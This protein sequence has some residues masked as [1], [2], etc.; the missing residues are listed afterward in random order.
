[1]MNLIRCCFVCVRKS[2]SG[3]RK[4]SAILPPPVHF[5]M[6]PFK[7][8]RSQLV[9]SDKKPKQFAYPSL[10]VDSGYLT[11]EKSTKWQFPISV[12]FYE[13]F[14][15]CFSHLEKKVFTITGSLIA[16]L[17][18]IELTCSLRIAANKQKSKGLFGK[19][20]HKHMHLLL[21]QK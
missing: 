12:L 2:C 18:N 1:M 20:I 6:K 9:F 15:C 4:K 16:H 21:F 17:F 11:P 14:Q 10:L 5:L 19:L 8:T 7:L 13:Q 3:K